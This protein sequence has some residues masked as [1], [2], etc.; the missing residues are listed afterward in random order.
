MSEPRICYEFP[1]TNRVRFFLRFEHLINGFEASINNHLDPLDAIRSLHQL[2]ELARH[3]DVKSEL[4]R[5]IRWQEQELYRFSDSSPVDQDKLSRIMREKQE[6]I[7]SLDGFELPLSDYTNNHFLNTT[8][9]RLNIPGGACN[10]D[11][12]QLHAWMHFSDD[13]KRK[14][15]ETWL[16]PFRQL[17]EALESALSLTR[18]SAQFSRETAEKGY[19]INEFPPHRH[20]YCLI[21]IR[22]GTPEIYPEVSAGPRHFTIYFFE[23]TDLGTRPCQARRDIQFELA[24]CAL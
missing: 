22:T 21:R 5:H 20:S 19:F 16:K 1:I 23:I 7:K 17:K 11:L 2:L 3:S 15:L 9:L 13:A 12:P 4:L 14:E 24:C 10:F 18:M 8:K 6:M